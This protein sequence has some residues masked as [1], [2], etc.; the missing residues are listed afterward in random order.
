M[1]GG[2]SGPTWLSDATGGAFFLFTA[3]LLGV[4]T[5][6]SGKRLKLPYTVLLLILGVLL[7]ALDQHG[8]LGFVGAS[9]R[10]WTSLTGRH[11]LVIFIPALLFG[12]A[13]SVDFHIFSREIP[14]MLLLALP[15]VV[16]STV[17]TALFARF[18]MGY[19]WGWNEAMAFGAMMSAT[20]PVAVVRACL[21]ARAGRA[22]IHERVMLR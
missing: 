10:L 11:M 12:S 6:V 13:S 7:S 1:S 4:L 19:N 21:C 20:D 18:A 8:G 14:Q 15:G 9:T 5:R 2:D 17:V 3:I 16:I 22:T